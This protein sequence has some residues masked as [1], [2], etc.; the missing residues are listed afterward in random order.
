MR[1]TWLAA[2][3][4]G[5]LGCG[6]EQGEAIEPDVLATGTDALSIPN[7]N[8]S[9]S[10]DIGSWNVEWFGS[11]SKG[12]ADEPLQQANTRK[13]IA[14]LN[15]DLLGLTEIVS[16]PA[17]RALVA[18]LPDRVGILS[19]DA[20]VERGADFYSAG[21]QK[22]ALVLHKRFKVD[23]A[24]L[25]LTEESFTFAGRPPLELSLS[26]TENGRPRTLVVMVVHLKAMGDADSH[27]RRTL[28]AAALKKLI[29]TEYPTRWVA[30]IGD[31]NDD[32]FSSTKPGAPSPF[33]ELV[34][35][36][37]HYRFTTQALSEADISTT[38]SF[39]STIDH[40]LVTNELFGR[41]VDGSAKVLRVDSFIPGYGNN[42]S[43]H[44]PVLSRYDLR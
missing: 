16:E 25:V 9:A 31:F 38:V 44:Y 8:R 12:P 39:G 43:D 15:L 27:R 19:S 26:F 29:D 30:V 40:H 32:L 42:T 20:T 14:G 18:G 3:V 1:M 2:V 33:A 17:F 41:Y 7:E 4:M 6:V 24:R 10:V 34:N 37:T 13:V 22:V 11:P 5:V 23:R 21:E 36:A 28:A 35:D